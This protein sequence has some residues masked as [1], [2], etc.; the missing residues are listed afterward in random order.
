MRCRTGV[1][2]G[3]RRRAPSPSTAAVS[4]PHKARHLRPPPPAS[5]S[6]PPSLPLS[7]SL[8]APC[9]SARGARPLVPHTRNPFTRH[10][11]SPGGW[12]IPRPFPFLRPCLCLSGP[13]P[14]RFS[15][16]ASLSSPFVPPFTLLQ[17]TNSSAAPRPL[18]ATPSSPVPYRSLTS[19]PPARALQSRCCTH[20]PTGRPGRAIGSF[21][22]QSAPPP[23][24]H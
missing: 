20:S 2:R 16:A 4:D 11:P 17:T 22:Y 24:P 18:L 23:Y 6:P 15:H 3:V 10:F 7:L 12:H 9:A 5:P 1:G 13:S 21:Y 8:R 19:P 14:F